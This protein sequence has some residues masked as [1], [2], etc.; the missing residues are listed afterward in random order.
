[1]IGKEQGLT[2][3]SLMYLAYSASL[4]R[5]EAKTR[6]NNKCH[7]KKQWNRA[8]IANHQSYDLTVLAVA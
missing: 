3:A 6:D 2:F 8:E 1:M 4:L 5:G 7:D